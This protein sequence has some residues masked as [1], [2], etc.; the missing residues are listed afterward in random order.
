MRLSGHPFSLALLLLIACAGSLTLLTACAG[1]PTL[2]PAPPQPESL[3][4]GPPGLIVARSTFSDEGELMPA[5]LLLLRPEDA[6]GEAWRVEKIGPRSSPLELHLGDTDEERVVFRALDDQGNPQG[7]VL[8]LVADP[9]RWRTQS[10]TGVDPER[11]A[12]RTRY[13][14]PYTKSLEMTGGNVFHQAMWFEPAYGEPGILT[15]SANASQLSLWRNRGESWEA[16]VL[17]TAVVGGKENRFRDVEVGD[18][19][20]DGEEELVLVT[21]DHGAVYVLEQTAAGLQPTRVHVEEWRTF[22]HE[23][24]IGDVNGDGKLEFFTTPSEPNRAGVHEHSGSIDMYQWNGAA[25]QRTRVFHGSDRHCKEILLA[26]NDGDGADELYAAVE[27]PPAQVEIRRF[28]WDGSTM[29]PDFSLALGRA[30][31]KAWCR[32]LAQADTDGDGVPEILAATRIDGIYRLVDGT[33]QNIVQSYHSSG[34]E[35]AI[36]CMDWDQDGCDDIFVASDQQ[37][38]V[39]RYSY[40]PATKTMKG[41]VILNLMDEVS[42]YIIW[43]VMPLPPGH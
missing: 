21:H 14:E 32:F 36:Y 1:S 7:E 2:P 15:I 40:D 42:T 17:W 16:E 11:V 31:T 28:R 26:D 4:A 30:D 12:W 43:N 38:S 39:Q 10:A 20:D 37:G 9:V 25:Y 18:V 5:E 29:A 13:D 6:R 24:E 35:H 34:F 23:V 41:S 33:A 19:D 22:V 8:E 3:A 27:A